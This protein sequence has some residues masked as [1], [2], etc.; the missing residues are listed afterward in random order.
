MNLRIV[1][2]DDHPMFREGLRAL[3]AAQSNM[4]V[5]AA[6]A[7]GQGA[8]EAV[9]EFDPDVVVLDL[10]MPDGD[11]YEAT[12]LIAATS[13]RTRILVLTSHDSDQEITS[14]L[15]AGA[16]GFLL[17]SASPTEIVD[18]VSA[19]ASGSSV[20]SDAALATLT[21]GSQSRTGTAPSQAFP[22]LTA[23][24]LQVLECVA[25]GMDNDEIAGSLH[26]SG[27]TVRNYVSNI[28]VK[29]GARDRTAAALA[30]RRRGIGKDT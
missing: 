25:S 1:L 15:A 5:M 6:V 7:S 28:L 13:S 21:G 2:A 9:H 4:S 18:A 14:A 11:G 3:L 20:L 22:E 23:R 27:K 26:L 24:E 29:L 17:K 16:H 12:R 30:A 10:S 8:V 19:I